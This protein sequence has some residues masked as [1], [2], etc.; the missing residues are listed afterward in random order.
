MAAIVDWREIMREADDRAVQVGEPRRF[1]LVD[2]RTRA[3]TQ[4]E[5]HIITKQTTP[6]IQNQHLYELCV[7]IRFLFDF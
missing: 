7:S 2:R 3:P 6:N 1:T 4:S 5:T